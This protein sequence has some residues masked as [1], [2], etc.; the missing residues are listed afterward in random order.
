MSEQN[1]NETPKPNKV[2]LVGNGAREHAIAKVLVKN[3]DVELLSFMSARN[4]GIISLS[5]EYTI[6]KLDDFVNLKEFIDE[7]KPGIAIIG[8]EAPLEA[9]IVDFLEEEGIGCVGPIKELAKLETSKS[10]TRL[11][12]KKY[13]VPGNPRF[14]VFYKDK[15]SEDE[16]KDF[17]SDIGGFVIKPDGLTGG[18]GVKVSGEHLKSVED[19]LNYC[20]E[21][22]ETHPAVVVEEKLVGEEFSLQCLTDGVNV[23]P[24]P[25]AQDHKRA[26]EDDT[27]PNTGGMGSYSAQDHLLPFLKKEHVDQ[28]LSITKRV[29]EALYKESGEYYKGVMY[30]GFIVTREG[31]KLI[32][33]NARF[34]DPEAMNVLP[35]IKSD[36]LRVCQAI[37]D[38][39]LGSVKLEF[40]KKAS[41]CKYAV[42]KGYPK[43]PVKGEKVDIADVSEIPG[44]LELFYAS[45]DKNDSGD[46]IM[47]GSRAIAFVGIGDSISDAEKLAQEAIENV[48][49]PIE[50]RKDIGTKQLIQ[51]R[52][53]HIN[54]L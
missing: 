50:F 42:P 23:L 37:V 40:D 12:M 7:F 48:K 45:I 25:P 28:A 2:L 19:G 49:G 34:G 14:E 9:G 16:I 26:Y 21:I 47:S 8:P 43:D 29:A 51:K 44:K 10:F 11:L 52:I 53:D 32:E 31:V 36:F 13:S 24:T 1:Q 41:V 22:L 15:N 5:K 54:Q 33:Y 38:S 4:P 17:L 18:K 39:D 20:L 27:G 30:G 3:K 6:S 35:L 46:L